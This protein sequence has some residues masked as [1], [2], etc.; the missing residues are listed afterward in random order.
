MLLIFEKL[1]DILDTRERWLTSLVFVFM[2]LVALLETVGVASI[3]PFMAVL[4]NPSVV[5]TNQYLA[6]LYTWLEYDS[7][8]AFLF[9]LGVVF[10]ILILGSLA[11]KA[12]AFWMQVRFAQTRNHS[13]SCRLIKN[14]LNQ[15]YDWF[16]NQHS[17]TLGASVLT[18]INKLVHGV[19]FPAI[20]LVSHGLVAM[21]LLVLMIAVDPVLALVTAMV[22][23]V[24]YAAL[25]YFVRHYIQRIGEEN[26]IAN[27][28]RFKI[29]QEAFGG[30][31]DVKVAGLEETFVER[32]R[33]PSLGMTRREISLRMLSEL[34]SFV[35]QALVL[36]GIMI[37]L[38]YFLASRGG[39]QEALPIF[40]LYAFAGY[41]M[42]PSLQA[43]YRFLSEIRYNAAVLE[44]LHSDL[45]LIQ[46]GNDSQVQ[47]VSVSGKSE[48][49]GLRETLELNDINYRYPEA[50]RS[51]L[52][53]VSLKISACSTVGLVG[54]TGSGKTTLV[55][56]IL[57]LLRP[58]GGVISVDGLQLT[59]DLLRAWQLSIGYVPQNIYLSD[60]TIK[61][62]IAFGIPHDRIDQTAVESA[63][64]AANLDKFVTNELSCG[65]DTVVGERG[66]RLSGGQRQRI[67]IARALY[68]NPDILILDE[69]TSALDNLTEQAV[70]DAVHNLGKKKT[71]IL[72]AHRL[73]TVRECDQ[74]FYLE[75]GQITAR[76]TYNE[77]LASNP[78]FRLMAGDGN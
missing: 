14:Y 53:S 77:L 47:N 23:G 45:K 55:D 38:L 51:A 7:T 13:W 11:L 3:M 44:S 6:T 31:K 27:R 67:G 62:N 48:P 72:I 35:M 1:Y 73:T 39:L 46:Q 8:D 10:L 22:L 70:M 52:K 9:F 29:A 33:L 36:G 71:I 66:V 28:E 65:Y 34:P 15:P 50:D 42:M 41:R 12:L 76:G 43:I 19:L 75:Q 60:D 56:M 17:G 21:F 16:L 30:V 64:T 5:E 18:E 54:S 58:E 37:M 59:P 25:F 40:S 20:Q 68:R 2:I 4:A 78:K 63:A 57:G 24:A 69:A 74:I 49:L 26:R 32:Y 61:S